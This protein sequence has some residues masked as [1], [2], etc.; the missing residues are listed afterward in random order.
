MR[1]SEVKDLKLPDYMKK[2]INLKKIFP[3]IEGNKIKVKDI[4]TMLASV[5]LEFLGRKHSGVADAKNI[6]R[7]VIELLKHQYRF[8][9]RLTESIYP[10]RMTQGNQN[11]K[12]MLLLSIQIKAKNP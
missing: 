4:D 7:V 10:Y 1:E 6:A 3:V 5:G 2:F 8:T 11:Y 12:Y 9:T